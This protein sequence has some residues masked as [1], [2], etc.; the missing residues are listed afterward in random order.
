MPQIA[1][2]LSCGC[3]AS[4]YKRAT[5]SLHIKGF[6]L[7]S[8]SVQEIIEACN[9]HD[10]LLSERKELVEALKATADLLY[11]VNRV[12][13]L[14]KE[15]FPHRSPSWTYDHPD[16]PIKLAINNMLSAL[17]KCMKN[18]QAHALLKRLEAE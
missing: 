2:V 1:Q 9:A 4:D 3:T 13:E 15:N 17:D 18:H 16:T 7:F 10:R 5:F 6:L 8:R 11:C 12:N 14:N